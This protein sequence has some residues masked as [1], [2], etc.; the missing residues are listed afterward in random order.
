MSFQK[1]VARA[2]HKPNFVAIEDYL[3]FSRDFLISRSKFVQ[4]TITC[5]NEPIY[6]FYQLSADVG[7]AISRPFNSN[8]LCSVV[9]LDVFRDEVLPL[10]TEERHIRRLDSTARSLL[11]RAIYTLQQSIG[12]SLDGLPAEATNQA[13]KVNGDLFERLIQLL[14][15]R[16]GINCTSASIKVPVMLNNERQFDMSF[17]HDLVISRN[18]EVRVIGSV[19]TSSKD[20]IGKIFVDKMLL[21]S[22]ASKAV[23]HVAVFLNDVQRG[24]RTDRSYKVASTFLSGHFKAYTI[25]LNPLDGVYYCDLRPNMRTDALLANEISSLDHLLCEDIWMLIENAPALK[26]EVMPEHI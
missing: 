8:L 25:K 26:A 23:P 24:K 5:Q 22:L 3:A 4:A 14:I 17:Q 12:I 9:E 19:K 13:R 18:D 6:R 21:N 11:N 16:L 20:R 2:V 15:V 10:L 1:F 7:H